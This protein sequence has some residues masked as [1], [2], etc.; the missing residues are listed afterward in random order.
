MHSLSLQEKKLLTDIVETIQ[1]GD[2][3][4]ISQMM[5]TLCIED[6]EDLSF[7]AIFALSLA[8]GFTALVMCCCLVVNCMNECYK[9]RNKKYEFLEEETA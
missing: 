3:K 2:S 7:E 6:N 5:K 1:G 9:N 4:A 8:G